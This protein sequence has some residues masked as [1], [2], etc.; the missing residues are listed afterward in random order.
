[1]KWMSFFGWVPYNSTMK[2]NDYRAFYQRITKWFRRKP[3]RIHG[4]HLA[5]QIFTYTFYLLYPLLVLVLAA[6]QNRDLCKAV[7]VPAVSFLIVTVVRRGINR[8]R[9]YEQ[10]ELDPLIHKNTKGK[11]FPSRHLFAS[12]VIAMTF[13]YFNV[14]AGIVLL[15]LSVIGGCI[16]VLGGVHYPSDVLAGFVCGLLA[17]AF[18]WIL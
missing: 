9:P 8:K 3:G 2:Q 7:L 6:N 18:L 14:P 1:M 11:S 15:V 10:W 17:G 4:L 12:G 5:N 16:R 13:L